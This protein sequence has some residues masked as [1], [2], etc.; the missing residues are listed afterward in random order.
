MALRN[1]SLAALLW[2]VPWEQGKTLRP[3]TRARENSAAAYGS[4]SIV[5]VFFSQSKSAFSGSR[6]AMFTAL[7]NHSLAALL[8]AVPWEQG[9]TLRAKTRARENSAAAYESKSIVFSFF[10]SK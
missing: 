4:K 7:W 10:L 8:W 1:H 9:K 5:L 3:K 2:A 6:L